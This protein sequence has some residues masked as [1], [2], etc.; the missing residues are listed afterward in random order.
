MEGCSFS[1]RSSR[2]FSEACLCL[3]W[4]GGRDIHLRSGERFSDGGTQAGAFREW[5]S[6]LAETT[7]PPCGPRR[8]RP[9]EAS[10]EL[11]SALSW[12]I[13]GELNELFRPQF[14]PLRTAVWARRSSRRLPST[15]SSPTQL[16]GPWIMWLFG[17]WPHGGDV[18]SFEQL[19]YL[20]CYSR[21]KICPFGSIDGTL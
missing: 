13:L 2:D 16:R 7:W 21:K 4:K 1:G 5:E 8:K 6:A 18:I 14:P 10:G 19:P 9:P 3:V 20:N 11:S 12:T 15:I 17:Y